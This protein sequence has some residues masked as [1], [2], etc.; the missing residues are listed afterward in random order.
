MRT[1]KPDPESSDCPLFLKKNMLLKID[2][3]FERKPN[4]F[5][6]SP[7]TFIP[8]CLIKE[9]GCLKCLEK[10]KKIKMLAQFAI[11]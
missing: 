8:T 7:S 9:K 1:E 2:E 3:K 4:K 11:E 10:F 5:C 6:S